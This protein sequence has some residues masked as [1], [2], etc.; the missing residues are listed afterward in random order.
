[1]IIHLCQLYKVKTSLYFI[2]Y[3]TSSTLLTYCIL[4]NLSHVRC[5]YNVC[6]YWN[7][8]SLLITWS[9]LL[10]QLSVHS[11]STSIPPMVTSGRAVIR[12]SFS[13]FIWCFYRFGVTSS[14]LEVVLTLQVEP[15]SLTLSGCVIFYSGRVF[16]FLLPQKV[17]CCTESVSHPYERHSLGVNGFCELLWSHD[18]KWHFLWPVLQAWL[19]LYQISGSLNIQ[20]ELTFAHPVHEVLDHT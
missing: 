4:H 6:H 13:L 5:I 19:M 7:M 17:F 9:Y 18:R 10:N 8:S 2:L 3:I 1:M 20:N 12:Q 15:S 11:R 14:H 16:F